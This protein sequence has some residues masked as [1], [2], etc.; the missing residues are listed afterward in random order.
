MRDPII[1]EENTMPKVIP[2]LVVSNTESSREFYTMLGFVQDNEGILDEKG[3]QWYSLAMGD[4]TVWLLREDT[5]EGYDTS[6]QR[7]PGVHLFLS[8][9]DVDGLYGKLQ[10]KAS[11]VEE[12]DTKWYGLREFK[13][14]DP[15][16]YIWIINMPVDEQ[17]KDA[18]DGQN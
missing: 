9:D 11:I 13:V 3:Q 6:L 4:A 2:E 17:A 8:V 12:I 10:G 18:V 1:Q 5:M 7:A 16:G 14:A 15:D